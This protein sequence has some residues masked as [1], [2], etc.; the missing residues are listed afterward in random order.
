ML[1]DLIIATGNEGKFHEFE[2]LFENYAK[3][4]SGKL[5]FAPDF[6]KLIVEETG[7]SYS[8]NATLKARAWVAESGF[9]CLADDSGLEAEALNGAPGIFS[10]RVAK[11]H[12]VEWILNALEGVS[13]RRARFAA[14]LALCL[15]DADKIFIAEGF[16]EGKI[17]NEPRGKNGFGYD[18]VFIPDGYEKTFAELDSKIKNSIS[19]RTKAFLNLISAIH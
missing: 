11:G 19:H 5:I 12:E 1:K 7:A 6:A 10:A 16:C 15:P 17:I 9:A 3:N 4:F 14:S 13:N 18:P 2:F 8:E